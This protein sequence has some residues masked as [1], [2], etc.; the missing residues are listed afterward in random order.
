MKLQIDNLDGLGPQDYTPMIDS[1]R[2][3][4]IVRRLNKPSVLKVGLLANGPN[5]VV[6]VSGARLDLRPNQWTGR[7]LGIS[8][9]RAEL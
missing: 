2:L 3:P 8:V 5:F 1:A 9:E 6:P 4:Q 7:I